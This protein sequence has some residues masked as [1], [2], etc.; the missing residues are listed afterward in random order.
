M[1]PVGLPWRGNCL[2]CLTRFRKAW[3]Q[4]PIHRVT[5][6]S[7]SFNLS[8]CEHKRKLFTCSFERYKVWED[9]AVGKA[10]LCPTADVEAWMK[11]K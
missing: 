5:N 1:G 9:T 6:N 11:A 4:I 8:G 3:L 10:W 7:P 2:E